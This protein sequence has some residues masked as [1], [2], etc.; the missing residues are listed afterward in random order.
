VRAEFS[1]LLTLP[2]RQDRPEATG[3]D[4]PFVSLPL[5]TGNDPGRELL[6]VW[7]DFLAAIVTALRQRPDERAIA[8]E[9][10]RAVERLAEE[11]I[12]QERGSAE[13][14]D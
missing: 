2:A 9:R 10:R 14:R 5:T 11:R 12:R 4:E 7:R 1:A 13:R 3:A 8:E 6:A